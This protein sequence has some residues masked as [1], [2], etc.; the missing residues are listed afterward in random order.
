MLYFTDK[1]IK[2]SIIVQ[3]GI[4]VFLLSGC[5]SKPSAINE[6]K[7]DAEEAASAAF[8][9]YDSNSD[10]SIS[11]EEATKFVSLNSVF[12]QCDKDSNGQVSKEE[13]AAR[14]QSWVDSPAKLVSANVSVRLDGRVLDGATVK[15]VPEPFL[16]GIIPEATGVLSSSGITSMIIDGADAPENLKGLHFVRLGFYRVEITH[17]SRKIP[18]KFNV[19]TTLGCEV[20]S[21]TDNKGIKFVLKSK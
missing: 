6:L 3:F 1:M 9:L 14:I 18:E 13:L 4:A 2:L 11:K 15:F 16:K 5:S 20:T 8:E 19:N 7:L 17:P 10:S 12:K 21:S